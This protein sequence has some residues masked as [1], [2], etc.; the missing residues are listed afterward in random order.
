MEV[1]SFFSEMLQEIVFFLISCRG[2]FSSSYRS[3]SGYIDIKENLLS[4]LLMTATLFLFFLNLS[5]TLKIGHHGHVL[6]C[7]L[8]CISFCHVSPLNK[9]NSPGLYFQVLLTLQLR[10]IQPL[11]LFPFCPSTV[12]YFPVCLPYW[13]AVANL[14]TVCVTKYFQTGL[15]VLVFLKQFLLHFWHSV[16]VAKI[17]IVCGC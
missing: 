2:V 12:L 14:S 17:N 15:P 11:A 8:I 13:T 7:F 6:R 1:F 16:R 9:I 4:L 5:A 3:N 10:V